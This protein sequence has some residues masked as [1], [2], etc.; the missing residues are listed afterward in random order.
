M[1][2]TN[3]MMTDQLLTDLNSAAT[4]LNQRQRQATQAKRIIVPS[5]D[6]VGASLAVTLRAALVDLQQAQRNGGEAGA[7]LQAASD[8]LDPILGAIGEVR[9]LALQGS[10]DSLNGSDRQ[11]LAGQ[12]NQDLEKLLALANGRSI[13]GYLFGGTQTTEAP[14]TATRDAN[15]FITAVAANP[16]GIDGRVSAQL[17]GGVTIVANVP[18]ADVFTQTVDIFQVLI[19][20]R[21]LLKT[22][23]ASDIAGTVSELDQARDQVLQVSTDVGSRIAQ[24]GVFQQQAD[25]DLTALKAR[26]SQIEDA[27]LAETSVEL[28]Q[29]Q[30]VYQA[31]LA[32]ASRILQTSLLDFLK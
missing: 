4:R 31:S 28:Q 1:R 29:A 16:K 30:N 20:V 18:G 13:D 8:Q 17:V 12:V 11:N 21:D 10:S 32:A 24:L 25:T 26:L 7:R 3:N 5:D 23:S 19:Q 14:F 15:G 2:V 6:P 9:D 27:D 22:G